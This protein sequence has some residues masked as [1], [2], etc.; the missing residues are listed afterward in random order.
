MS[1]QA[2]ISRHPDTIATEI[3]DE[4]VLMSL[5]TGQTFG[6]DKRGARIWTLLE[7]PR[8]LE[9]LVAE[10]VK[11]YNATPEQCQ[12]DVAGFLAKMAE[13]QLV[14]VGEPATGNV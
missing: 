1:P 13:V 3:S 10:L 4:I 2:V 12:A 7:Q 9:N 14:A 11:I 6:L 8:S 5:T